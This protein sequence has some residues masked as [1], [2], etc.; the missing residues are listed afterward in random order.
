MDDARVRANIARG[1]E[2]SEKTPTPPHRRTGAPHLTF[3]LT[4]LAAADAVVTACRRRVL[5]CIVIHCVSVCVC[6]FSLIHFR[7]RPANTLAGAH[8]AGL[9]LI[10]YATTCVCFF[11]CYV[12]LL[13]GILRKHPQTH[14]HIKPNTFC[15]MALIFCKTRKQLG[16]SSPFEP[17]INAG[18]HKTQIKHFRTKHH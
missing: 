5:Y 11:A 1:G 13:L 8:C 16:I 12:C 18:A 15:G 2:F 10:K 14:T 9:S 4:S 7:P 6:E 17:A 3:E